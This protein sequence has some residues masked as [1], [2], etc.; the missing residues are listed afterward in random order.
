M[1]GKAREL[2]VKDL[3]EMSKALRLLYKRKSKKPR[4]MKEFLSVFSRRI[5]KF[6]PEHI[7]VNADGSKQGNYVDVRVEIT[8]ELLKR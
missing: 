5:Y 3:V 7:W 6:S 4:T 1:Q 2:G 8:K